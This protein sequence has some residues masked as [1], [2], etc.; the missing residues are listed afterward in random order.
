MIKVRRKTWD[1]KLFINI[2]GA[3]ILSSFLF[4]N[5]ALRLRTT[6]VIHIFDKN[7]SNIYLK[8]ANCSYKCR[9]WFKPI[10][11]WT[12]FSIF[13][14]MI[15][16][17]VGYA[18]LLYCHL[19]EK[20]LIYLF[21]IPKAYDRICVKL[22]SFSTGA[23]SWSCYN[24]FIQDSLVTFKS[25]GIKETSHSIKLKR[26]LKVHSF[27]LRVVYGLIWSLIEINGTRRSS[28]L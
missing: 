24:F 21:F 12:N 28:H 2:L 17:D 26:L 6:D 20:R 25:F 16:L 19:Q 5:L 27:S 23:L 11:I 22:S 3:Y 15:F 14:A 7:F 18:V 10:K 9:T 1:E 8:N 4:I 13:D